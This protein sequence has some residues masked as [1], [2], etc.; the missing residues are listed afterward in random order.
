[1]YTLQHTMPNLVHLRHPL[2]RR[3]PPRQENH[4]FRP[5]LH[6]RIDH[7]LREPLPSLA[8]MAIRLMRPHSQT[9]IEKQDTAICP[10]G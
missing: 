5:R 6:N 4:P 1:M 10:W 3:L 8:R 9:R 2:L 7:F